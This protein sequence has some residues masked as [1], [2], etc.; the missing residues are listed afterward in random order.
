MAT[1]SIILNK[2]DWILKW[3][4]CTCFIT[5][6]NLLCL[7]AASEAKFTHGAQF[8]S[9]GNLWQLSGWICCHQTWQDHTALSVSFEQWE[10]WMQK[11][12]ATFST[13]PFLS[14]SSSIALTAEK[15][16]F[17]VLTGWWTMHNTCQDTWQ[18]TCTRISTIALT[19]NMKNGPIIYFLYQLHCVLVGCL[20][21]YCKII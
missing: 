7:T 19:L 21:I 20:N 9:L 16:N 12:F 11:H 1:G 5:S 15:L 3:L 2:L 8:V 10:L 18:Y 14:S 6:L 17:K 13:Q 4:Q